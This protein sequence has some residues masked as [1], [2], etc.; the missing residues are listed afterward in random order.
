M[1]HG[2]L[3]AAM[4]G[5]ACTV[6]GCGDNLTGVTPSQSYVFSFENDT[7]G[8]TD[9]AM[10]IDNPPVEWNIQR[11]IDMARD[12]TASMKFYLANYNDK[13]K[14]WMER[15]FE[16]DS[17]ANYRVDVRYQFATSDFGQANLWRIITG[18][19]SHPVTSVDD[20]TMR[21]DTGNGANSDAGYLWTGKQYTVDRRSSA[22]GK[23]YVSIG[24]WGTWETPRTYYVDFV[25]IAFFKL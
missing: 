7:Q 17:S 8:W 16:V 4:L 12:G 9:R 20:L 21:D 13:G 2:F 19:Q 11:A 25:Y 15:A 5:V 23:I 1:R 6:A 14:I 22:G 3:V 10:D 18:V 24:V